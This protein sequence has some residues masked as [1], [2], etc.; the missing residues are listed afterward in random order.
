MP[1]EMSVVLLVFDSDPGVLLAAPPQA[2]NANRTAKPAAAV[3]T[4]LLVFMVLPFEW[5]RLKWIRQN[6]CIFRRTARSASLAS[7]PG[8]GVCVVRFM[9]GC[10][11]DLLRI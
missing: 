6:E 9:R 3:W 5:F 7:G 8:P 11:P 1:S 4:L 10:D 2:L